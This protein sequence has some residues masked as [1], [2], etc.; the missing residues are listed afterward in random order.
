MAIWKQS[1]DCILALICNMKI[2]VLFIPENQI[3]YNL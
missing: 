3:D 1:A 2:M